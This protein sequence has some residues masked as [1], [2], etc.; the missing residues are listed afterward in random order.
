MLRVLITLQ[1]IST[2]SVL[3]EIAMPDNLVS[4]DNT[5]DADAW[6]CDNFPGFVITRIQVIVLSSNH[7]QH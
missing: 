3:S 1:R 4:S 2:G 6:V 7:G 5:Y